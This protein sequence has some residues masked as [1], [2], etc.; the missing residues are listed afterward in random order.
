MLNT[1]FGALLPMVVTFLHGFKAAWRHDLGRND[2]LMMKA[3]SNQRTANRG[4][5]L[6]RAALMCAPA[7]NSVRLSEPPNF[8]SSQLKLPQ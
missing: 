5:R 1:I 6:T 2:A 7:Q 3:R 4:A 8:P